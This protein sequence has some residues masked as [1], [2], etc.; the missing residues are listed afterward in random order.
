MN[1]TTAILAGAFVGGVIG[2]WRSDLIAKAHRSFA[3]PMLALIAV[4]V[5]MTFM[6]MISGLLGLAFVSMFLAW[7]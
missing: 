4:A 1:A 7:S 6:M 3:A 2:W 5:L